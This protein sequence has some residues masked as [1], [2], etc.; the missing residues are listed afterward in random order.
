MKAKTEPKAKDNPKTRMKNKNE[1]T[2]TD[3]CLRK[4]NK[5][6]IKYITG[7]AIMGSKRKSKKE[8]FKFC[9]YFRCIIVV[10]LFIT[11]Y[12]II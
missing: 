1:M 9:L 5:N 10:R 4:L 12:I 2:I 7:Y 11:I 6:K 3:T 8:K